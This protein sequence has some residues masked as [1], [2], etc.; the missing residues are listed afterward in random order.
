MAVRIIFA[1]VAGS[2]SGKLC[3][4]SRGTD[5]DQENAG[6]VRES[7]QRRTGVARWG[8][9]ET[10]FLPALLVTFVAV[11]KSDP[12]ETRSRARW[13]EIAPAPAAAG[14]GEFCAAARRHLIRPLRGHLPLKG[15]ANGGVSS[16][17]RLDAAAGR[18]TRD[19][20]SVSFADTCLPAGRSAGLTR[21]RRIIQYRGPLKGECLGVRR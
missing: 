6:Y 11:D 19:P 9:A 17:G 10:Q 16:G 13:R 18:R 7:G 12:S 1:V 14:T 21:H 8:S 3:W 20:S 15:K 4:H 5:N 2:G